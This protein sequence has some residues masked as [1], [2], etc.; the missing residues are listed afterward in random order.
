MAF[1]LLGERPASAALPVRSFTSFLRYVAQVVKARRN[2]IELSTLLEFEDHRL[3]DLGVT[4]HD[5][6]R[7]LNDTTYDIERMRNRRRTI[8]I[9]PPR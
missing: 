6:A 4:R 7:A 5:V 9:W 3:W 1:S 8:D 2:R